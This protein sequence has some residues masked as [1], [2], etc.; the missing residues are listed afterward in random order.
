M[1]L[2]ASTTDVTITCGQCGTAVPV[3]QSVYVDGGGSDPMAGEEFRPGIVALVTPDGAVRE[4]ADGIAFGNGMAVTPDNS[5]LIVAESYASRLTAFD[6]AADG[7]LSGRR[8]WAALDGGVPD[9]ICIDAEGAVW[10][11][12]VPHKRCVRVREGGEVLATVDVDRGCFACM[13]GGPDGRTL[14]IMAAEWRGMDHMLDDDRTG[15]VLATV[16]PAPHA[17]RP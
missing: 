15:Q 6:I 3:S 8:V 11:A 7:S 16:A 1:N 10:Y 13:L 12:D 5:T 4:V 17:G 2:T 14:Y 9:G